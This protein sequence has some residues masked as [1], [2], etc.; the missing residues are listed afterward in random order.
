MYVSDGDTV[1][2]NLSGVVTRVRLIGID[3]P[4]SKDPNEPQGCYGP[5]AALIAT[6]L[7]P[8]GRQVLV[9]TDP[10][11]DRT[12]RFKRLLAYVI[13][14]G[15]PVTLNEQLVLRGAARVYVY[16][17]NRPPRRIAAFRRAEQQARDARRGLWGR[18]NEG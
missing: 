18:C 5:Q 12:D 11:Q 2:V 9:V 6:R 17:R 16:R 10:T 8:R 13:V 15:D 1:G 14:P 7:L 3:A 4:E